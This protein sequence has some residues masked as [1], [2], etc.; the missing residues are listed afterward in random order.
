MKSVLSLVEERKASC[1]EKRWKFKG[2][3]GQ[4]IIVRDV[5]EKI[6]TWID[7]F[8]A[9]GDVA[10]SYDPTHAALP[11]AGIR[12]ILQVPP[13]SSPSLA[14]KLTESYPIEHFQRCPNIWCND[15]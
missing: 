5:L 11:W 13:T 2:S 15:G 8:K 12:F 1:I 3:K 7:K 9:V 6:A 4:T 10:V 14:P